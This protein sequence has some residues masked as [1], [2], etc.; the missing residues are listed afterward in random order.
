MREIDRLGNAL[1]SGE[2]SLISLLERILQPQG[3]EHRLLLVV[4]Q[5]EELFTLTS[6][7]ERTA[8]IEPPARGTLYPRVGVATGA[9]RGFLWTISPFTT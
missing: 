8:F 3:S 2:L 4:D 1:Q 5:F 9:A 7:T 6:S